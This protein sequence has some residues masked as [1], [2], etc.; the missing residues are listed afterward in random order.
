MRH[1][2]WAAVAV[3]ALT[4][5]VGACSK[6]TEAPKPPSMTIKDIMDT[7]V[8]PSGDF[9]FASVQ[10]ISDDKGVRRKVPASDAEWQEVRRHLIVLDEASRT[11]AAGGL[12]AAGPNDK[13]AAPGVENEP[14]EIDRLIAAEPVE[15]AT[16]AHR[17]GEAAAVGIRAV[18][19]KNVDELVS[20][21]GQI[22]R[23]CE[24]CHLHFWYPNDTRAREQAR[25]QG[26]PE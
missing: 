3:A 11:L 1:R 5:A 24:G 25:A 18:G 2:A 21:L 12:K 15:F 4:L 23:A 22:D 14:A 9:L 13:S 17:L 7:A 8:D 16:R 6:K 10:D 20:A 19:A 26:I